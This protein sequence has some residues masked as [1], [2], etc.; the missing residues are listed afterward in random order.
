MCP[1]CF[2]SSMYPI[3]P[4]F[5]RPHASGEAVV[6]FR[7][8]DD[9]DKRGKVTGVESAVSWGRGGLKTG[10]DGVKAGISVMRGLDR[11]NPRINETP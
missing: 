2:D 1:Q 11:G 4:L 7:R 10:A 9:W 6:C 8:G 3:V 5:F